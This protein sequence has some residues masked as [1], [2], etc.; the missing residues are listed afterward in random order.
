MQRIASN[1]NEIEEIKNIFS[2][3][4]ARLEHGD[5]NYLQKYPLSEKRWYHS[6]NALNTK[7]GRNKV[8]H[9]FSC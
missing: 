2:F 3:S 8:D 5:I 4:I 1:H 6:Y 7:I 9:K